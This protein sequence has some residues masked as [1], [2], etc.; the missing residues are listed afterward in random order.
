MENKQEIKSTLESFQALCADYIRGLETVTPDQLKQREDGEWSLGQMYVH[1]IQSA[2]HMHLRNADSCLTGS[3]GGEL[4]AGKTPRGVTAF[5][6]G[7]F[8]PVR[9]RVPDSP[10]Y[11][12]AQPES[13][14]ELAEG[15]SRVSRAMED[16]SNR[17]LESESS[18][19]IA[20]PGFGELNAAEWYRLVEM[21]YRHHLRQ[22]ERLRANLA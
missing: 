16:M 22:E 1:L 18:R 9:I 7:E 6:Q 15:L 19:V 3:G 14:E 11:T 4:S 12:P 10:Q 20:H 8:P 21:H 17:L 13:K 2:L 5:E